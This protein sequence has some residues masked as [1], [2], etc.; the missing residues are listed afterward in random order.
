MFAPLRRRAQSERS[1]GGNAA[2][3][4][5][6]LVA[7]EC[8]LGTTLNA[9]TV[10]YR[11]QNLESQKGRSW[12]I[13]RLS[14]TSRLAGTAQQMLDLQRMVQ[15]RC[16]CMRRMVSSNLTGCILAVLRPWA[17]GDYRSF[18]TRVSR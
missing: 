4:L 1:E 10:E 11:I 7:V 5:D 3:R 18:A 15:T 2:R 16:C 9:R 8:I 12:M 14:R 6:I 17:E 13:S